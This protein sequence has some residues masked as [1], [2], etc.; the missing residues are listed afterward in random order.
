MLANLRF[1]FRLFARSPLFSLAVVLVLGLGIGASTTVFTLVDAYLLKPLPFREPERLV[2]IWRSRGDS[3]A[4]R[5]FGELDFL[6]LKQQAS[7]FSQI[8]A[9]QPVGLNLAGG[10]AG[11]EL[12]PEHLFGSRVSGD[13]FAALGVAPALGRPFGADEDR[14]GHEQV[15]VLSD[16]LFRRRFR[17][18][19]SIVGRTIT[20]DG[21]PHQ[22]IGVMPPS[23]R[24]PTNLWTAAPAEFWVPAALTR[25]AAANH[26]ASW[27][28]LGR[29]APGASFEAAGAEA[30]AIA[31]RAAEARPAS[32]RDQSFFLF[33]LHEL[34]T[35]RV[36]PPLVLLFAATLLL[37]VIASANVALLLSARAAAR[38]GEVAVRA[39]LGASRPRLVGQ[40]LAEH[41]LLALAGGLAGFAFSF[42]GVGLAAPGYEGA[43]LALRELE[44]DARVF[45]FSLL[46]A[47]LAGVGFGLLPALRASKTRLAGLLKE[48][49]TRATAGA[50]RRRA[51]AALLVAEVALSAVLLA[52]STA[53][54]RG[55]Y[56]ALD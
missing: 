12:A 44:P 9:L 16:A 42:A 40:F 25:E 30:K 55:F 4:R 1:A 48:G 27:N 32:N 21:K 51:Q 13:Y 37:L 10:G 7:S 52:G 8:A 15:V 46:V 38:G 11:A 14:P 23:F 41:L 3:P 2:S 5:P 20:L 50:E 28:L 54:A 43:A 19:P 45:A 29:L 56:A 22:V 24:V 34:L 17:A 49:A 35:E 18:D 39:A 26:P 31:R 33:P 36:K 53:V 6:D 47:S